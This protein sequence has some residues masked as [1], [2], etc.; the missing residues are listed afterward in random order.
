MIF[1]FKDYKLYLAKVEERRP[2]KGRGFRAELARIMGCQTAYVSQVLN[3]RANFSLEQA[4]AVSK[5]LVH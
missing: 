3:G 4:Q 5:L 1:D 2:L